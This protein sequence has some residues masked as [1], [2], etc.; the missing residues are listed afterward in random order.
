MAKTT[1][2]IDK[3]KNNPNNVSFEDI[4]KLLE[5]FGFEI[6]KQSSGTSHFVFYKKGC[7]PITIPFRKPMRR[8]IVKEII[9][10]I[11]ECIDNDED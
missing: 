5:F 6:R 10:L 2:L 9:N 1:K 3:I 8:Y 4:R 11:E 7:G